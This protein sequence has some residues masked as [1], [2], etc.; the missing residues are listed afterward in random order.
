MF[1]RRPDYVSMALERVKDC[2]IE[3][4]TNQGIVLPG[5]ALGPLDYDDMP[6]DVFDYTSRVRSVVDVVRNF[7]PLQSYGQDFN[8]PDIT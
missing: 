8:I 6:L 2:Q 4:I 1:A 5:Q 7:D 3:T